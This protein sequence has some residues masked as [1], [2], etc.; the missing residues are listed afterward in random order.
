MAKHIVGPGDD[1]S[2]DTALGLPK[3]HSPDPE[4]SEPVHIHPRAC[5]LRG[6]RLHTHFAKKPV[7][8]HLD[9]QKRVDGKIGN[10]QDKVRPLVLDLPGLKVRDLEP[11]N[12][13]LVLFAK[14]RFE[15]QRLVVLSGPIHHAR[16]D[17]F[18]KSGP[19]QTEIDSLFGK[20]GFTRRQEPSG[21]R[22][23]IQDHPIAHL[24][25]HQF[26]RRDLTYAAGLTPLDLKILTSSDLKSVL[27]EH[28]NH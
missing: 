5:N 11:G 2:R 16:R 24:T 26:K 7:P 14:D 17:K 28:R 15:F 23:K 6:R 18:I 27:C 3:S 22:V 8:A 13:A 25:V 20:R 1:K 4:T 12:L 9:R 10:F 19:R 21:I